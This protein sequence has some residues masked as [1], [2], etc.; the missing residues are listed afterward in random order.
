MPF[1][2]FYR[3]RGGYVPEQF[4]VTAD[5]ASRALS[6]PL[7]ESITVAEQ[8]AVVAALENTM[9]TLC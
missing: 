7:H 3:Q 6:L 2:T 4:P 5:V 9:V 8:D 1:I